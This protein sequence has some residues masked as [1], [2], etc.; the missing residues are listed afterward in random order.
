MEQTLILV[1]PDALK[2][3]LTG[4]CLL[5]LSE[6][7]TGLRFAGFKVVHVHKML[8]EAHY[9]EHK[10]KPFFPA[11]L[12]YICGRIHWPE[13][14]EKR[15]VIA[16]VQQGPDA[17]KKIREICGPTDP[18]VARETH[19]GC[20]RSLGTIQI[21]QDCS[22]KTVDRRIDNLLHASAN[23]EDAERE[24][25]LWF[26]PQDMPPAMHAF[27]TDRSD[28][29]YYYQDGKLFTEHGPG[30]FCLL[31][32]NDIAWKSDLDALRLIAAGN[33]VQ[34]SL[35]SISAKYLINEALPEE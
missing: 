35:E 6:Y 18:H 28:R 29:H 20:I 22:G 26:R 3:S 14:P 27:P 17:V 4:Y 21:V 13:N 19:P 9:A 16:I 1:K 31:A 2:N 8:A 12:D 34:I 24:I 10:A 33:T 25:K 5:N 15:R 7:H 11:L 30:R 23:A 32:P